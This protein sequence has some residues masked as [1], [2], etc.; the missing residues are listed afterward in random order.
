[1]AAIA[2]LSVCKA[3]E[4]GVSRFR[5]AM[6]SRP[7][8][9]MQITCIDDEGEFAALK[10]DWSRAYASDPNAEVFVSW[11]WLD[12]WLQI[13]PH[14]WFV[15]AAREREGDRF[16]AF[17]PL[18]T[19]VVSVRGIPLIRELHM[20]GKPFGPLTG[21]VADPEHEAS[22]LAALGEYVRDELA[23]DEFRLA[24]TIDPR[25]ASL[26]A[27][28]ASPRFEVQREE[29]LC[30]PYLPL[31]ASW[32]DYLQESLSHKGRFNLRR[33]LRQIE[34]LEGYRTTHPTAATIDDEIRTLL[35][36]WESRWGGAS[37]LARGEYRHMYREAFEDGRLFMRT[38]WVHETPIASLAAFVDPVKR[39]VSYY[40]SGFDSEFARYSPGKA[41]V[42]HCIRDAIAGK[43]DTFDFLVG[44]HEYK[45]SFFGAKERYATTAVV[46]R[47]SLRRTVGRALL[48]VRARASGFRRS[49]RPGP[50]TA[51]N[52]E[53]VDGVH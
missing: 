44:G 53:D 24:D 46:S 50:S 11:E 38:L 30:C 17:L 34:A 31:P 7:A 8:T 23:W 25:G 52:G 49:S 12:S 13:S 37:D 15:L 9:T 22:A 16:V 35:T 43:F 48:G 45:L 40:T 19:R 14:R 4:T 47:K 20:A 32:D 6:R 33:S 3:T 29:P 21:F 18:A 51:S 26:L 5:Q 2:L 36:L 39:T 41:I 27:S 1:M 28:F 10:G 42:G